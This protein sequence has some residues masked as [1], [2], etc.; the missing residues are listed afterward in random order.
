MKITIGKEELVQGLQA[1]QNVVGAR[2]TLPILGNVLLKAAGNRLELRATDLDVTVECAVTAEVSREGGTTLSAKRLFGLVRE[3]ESG[4]IELD[5]SDKDV[6]AVQAGS[7][8]YKLNGISAEEFPALPKFKE[9]GQVSLP[10]GTFREMLR[11]TAYA[12]S[13][14]ESRFVLNGLY[15]KHDGDKLIIVATDGR[16]LALVEEELEGEGAKEEF[17]VPA[18]AVAELTRLLGS[19]G[20]VSI[21][22]SD[23]QVEFTLAQ[24]SGEPVKVYSKLVEG[25]YPDYKQVIPKDVDQRVTLGREELLH[26]LRRVDQVTSDKA[27]SVNLKFAD[28]NLTINATSPEVGEGRESLAI[29]YSGPEIEVAFNP[30]FLMDPLK[31]LE[32]DEVY[33]E[34]KDK[35]SPGVLKSNA[36]FL[37]VLMPMRT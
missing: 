8:K 30:G 25:K 16:R 35:L 6:C 18:K 10:Q 15:M 19:D 37:Y 20:E 12:I 4:E 36:P 22:M 7:S 23:T 26:A 1:V 3:I 32:S 2:S 28:N 21:R 24:E 33:I 9:S 14:D 13:T 11:K 34:L 5:V 27:N 17:I 31:V 29:N